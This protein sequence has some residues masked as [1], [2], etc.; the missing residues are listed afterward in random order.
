MEEIKSSLINSKEMSHVKDS[1][2]YVSE[3]DGKEKFRVKMLEYINDSADNDQ[4]EFFFDMLEFVRFLNPGDEAIAYTDPQKRIWLNSPNGGNVGENVRI[5]DFIYDHECLHQLWDT[6]AVGDKIKKEG[7]EYN[8]YILNIA[9]DCVINDYLVYCRKKTPFENGIFPDYIEKNY[10]IKYERTKDTQYTLYLK[11]LEKAKE[12]EKDQKLQDACKE[13]DGKIKPKSVNKMNGGGGGPQGQG[14]KHSEDYKKGWTDAIQDTLDKKIDP[15]KD[16]PK[17]TGNNEYDKGYSDAIDN[18]KK[19]LEDG[20]TMSSGGGGGNSPGTDLPQ[21]PWDTEQ[22]QQSGG[23]GSGKSGDSDKDKKDSSDNNSDDSKS[24]SSN[25]SQDPV[26]KSQ[27]AAD[28]AKDAA[29]KAQAAAD[30]AKK[31]ANGSNSDDKDSDDKEGSGSGD[32]QKKAEEAQKAADKAKKAA[33]DAQKAADEA[34]EASENG[35]KKGAE[36]AAKEAQDAADKAKEAAKEAGANDG[37]S[38]DKNQDGKPSGKPGTQVGGTALESDADLEG[39]KKRAQDTIEKYKNKISGDLGKFIKQ[40][41]MA[42]TL[43]KSGLI[44]DGT[45][46]GTSLPWN[47]QMNS[48]IKAYVKNKV[49]QKQREF[50]RTYQKVKRGSGFVEYGK[51]IE[52][53]KKLRN[54]KLLINVAFYV[55]RSGS[56]GNSINHVFD[57]LYIISEAL[58]KQFGKEKVVSNVEFKVYAFDYGI[59]EIKYGKRCDAQGGTMPFENLLKNIGQKTKDYMINVILTDA[60]FDINASEVD[61]FIKDI[62]GCILFV[63]NT[64]NSTMKK[65]SEKYKTQLFYVKADSQFTI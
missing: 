26:D 37:E 7:I 49:F 58:K 10:G 57:A 53:G 8:H 62:D 12:L 17:K 45:K 47:K 40:C 14:E 1:L 23:S 60:E 51:P 56:M 36:K 5:W 64:D 43:K 44:T 9:S 61:R 13:F 24:D 21:I 63:T 59:Q 6:F 28:E 39:I 22:E 29:A 41:T 11:L 20:V 54:D 35:D 16:S 30:K 15:L 25:D 18:I 46:K 32:K 34:K 3:Q 19:G 52:R 48:Y 65:L 50:K 31:E 42:S 4:D 2:I 38:G 55:D 27:K 33:Q